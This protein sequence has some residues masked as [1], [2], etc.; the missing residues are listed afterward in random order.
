MSGFGDCSARP[1][2]RLCGL[3]SIA[4]VEVGCVHEH[5]WSGPLCKVHA[6]GISQAWCLY[7]EAHHRCPVRLLTSVPA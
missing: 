4:H 1:G 5:F 7:C 2:L 6:D 3:P